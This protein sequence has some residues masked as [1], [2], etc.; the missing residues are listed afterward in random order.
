MATASPYQTALD[1]FKWAYCDAE[2]TAS[3]KSA[4]DSAMTGGALT[5]GGLDS[6]TTATKNG[7]TMQK[8]IGLS[9]P[10]RVRSLRWACLWLD[11][12]VCPSQRTVAAI[13]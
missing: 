9:E 12:G 5:K 3:V 7:V 2:K 4:Y 13:L 1:L 10:D 11:A 8:M 6:I